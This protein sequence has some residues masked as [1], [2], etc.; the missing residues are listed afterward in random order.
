MKEEGIRSSPDVVKEVTQG[1]PQQTPARYISLVP[2]PPTV[3]TVNKPSPVHQSIFIQ[4]TDPIDGTNVMTK[5]YRASRIGNRVPGIINFSARTDQADIMGFGGPARCSDPK[6]DESVGTRDLL[7]SRKAVLPSQVRKQEKVLEDAVVDTR[8]V[9]SQRF[10]GRK[11]EKTAFQK[12]PLHKPVSLVP[13]LSDKPGYHPPPFSKD[14][15]RPL[16]ATQRGEKAM[17]IQKWS[18]LKSHADVER[19]MAR[20]RSVSIEKLNLTGLGVEVP[21]SEGHQG[22][23]ADELGGD[24]GSVDTRVSVARLRSAFLETANA[25]RNQDL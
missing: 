12:P 16:D 7:K 11:D 5:E 2:G 14:W 24:A 22:I 15:N 19:G 9:H 6:L 18:A 21:H 3:N 10:L 20:L 4:S 23:N 1:R 13:E 17:S 25:S 8:V